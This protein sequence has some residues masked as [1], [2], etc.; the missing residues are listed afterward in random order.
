M[1]S[2]VHLLLQVVYIQEKAHSRSC[3]GK[4]PSVVELSKNY[5]VFSPRDSRIP[6]IKIPLNDRSLP[7]D[8]V[9]G[10][11]S[12]AEILFSAKITAWTEVSYAQGYV[13][14]NT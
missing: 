14:Y 13:V 2:Y 10:P 11:S 6:R 4:L 12:Y 5:V 9:F 7:P 1:L 3:V 8:Y